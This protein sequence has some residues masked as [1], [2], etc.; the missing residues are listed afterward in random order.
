M[1]T[2]ITSDTKLQTKRRVSKRTTLIL[3][4]FEREMGGRDALVEILAHV[5]EATFAAVQE[6]AIIASL[7]MDPAN[8]RKHLGRLCADAGIPPVSL[9]RM[10]REGHLG[11]A[12][13][14][15]MRKV[16]Q[17]LPT[18]V[19]DV[20]YRALP[21]IV[22]CHTCRGKGWTDAE[23]VCWSCEGTGKAEEVPDLDRQKLALELGGMLKK[24]PATQVQ[25]N[26][27]ANMGISFG[28]MR[29][30]QAANDRLVYDAEPT[31]P[32]DG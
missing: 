17:S 20:M 1:S 11:R 3:A 13:A 25:V 9:L 2:A 23:T 26:Q 12:Q 4:E 32:K 22:K 19:E 5:P 14:L 31:E 10:L 8:D 7:V 21:I 16:A 24:V 27:Q 28:S 29:E 6:G 30:F 18:V 15:A